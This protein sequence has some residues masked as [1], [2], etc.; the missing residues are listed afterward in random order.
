[1]RRVSP[2]SPG[3]ALVPFG[4]DDALGLNTGP[5]ESLSL[6]IGGAVVAIL[7]VLGVAVMSWWI[8]RTGTPRRLAAI[9]T[10]DNLTGLG[11]RRK[12]DRDVA[13][14]RRRAAPEPVGLLMID[15][16]HFARFSDDHGEGVGDE[17]LQ[18][19]GTLLADNVRL[20]DV[21]YRYGSEEFCVLLPGATKRQAFAVAERLRLQVITL[22]LTVPATITLSVGL[23]VGEAVGLSELTTSADAA[24]CVARNGGRN[25]TA[26]A[27][28]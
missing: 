9:A 24:L 7:A 12:F 20:G 26:V 22:E 23:A 5:G 2:A 1:M 10:T 11:N 21:V 18:K 4:L 13:A 3:I 27:G 28:G 14:H 16:D 8:G 25:R 19:V 15:V 17:V 6:M